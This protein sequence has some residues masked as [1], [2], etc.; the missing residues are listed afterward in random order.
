MGRRGLDKTRFAAFLGVERSRVSRWLSGAVVPGHEGLAQI[1]ERLGRPVEE[2]MQ[3]ARADTRARR[4]G[5]ATSDSL[6][7][8]VAR[9]AA[10]LAERDAQVEEMRAEIAALRARSRRRR[11]T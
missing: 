10:K 3:S 5:R 11:A 7:D 1:A 9:L 4:E 8:E 2:I 6:A